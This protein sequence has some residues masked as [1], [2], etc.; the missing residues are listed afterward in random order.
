MSIGAWWVGEKINKLLTE[1]IADQKV[2][3]SI[4]ERIEAN[5][6]MLLAILTPAPPAKFI[7]TYRTDLN[8][9]GEQQ[10]MSALTATLDFDLLDSGTATATLTVVDAA[11]LTTTLPAG[12]PVPTW[13]TSS[14][15][16]V[17]TPAPD[18]MSAAISPSTPP[19]LATGVVITVTTTLATGTV[20]TGTGQPID[21]IGGGPTGFLISE[22]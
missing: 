11:G 5:T 14:P 3:I 9:T 13:V 16:I 4:N 20:I 15:A 21:V 22:Q 19:V 7:I 17:L 12:T 8:S 2:L 1:L 6:Q 18:G 10:H